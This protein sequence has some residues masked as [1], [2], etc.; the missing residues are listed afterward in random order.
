MLFVKNGSCS[1][2]NPGLQEFSNTVISGINLEKDPNQFLY[3]TRT[4]FSHVLEF[5]MNYMNNISTELIH[6]TFKESS[7]RYYSRELIELI[8]YKVVNDFV[9][10]NFLFDIFIGKP[11]NVKYKD[12]EYTVAE[13]NQFI[14]ETCFDLTDCSDDPGL[15]LYNHNY[16]DNFIKLTRN[17]INQIRKDS[18]ISSI[19]RT[20]K[21][22]IEAT[23]IQT[24]DILTV[25]VIWHGGFLECC[26]FIEKRGKYNG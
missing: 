12:I 18:V 26:S 7:L 16:P 13:L 21:K 20:L 24:H 23:F 15:Y 5:Y 11:V 3:I 10:M 2:C 19:L 8:V 17:I 22:K 4:D 6:H 25:P 14:E 1:L 9:D